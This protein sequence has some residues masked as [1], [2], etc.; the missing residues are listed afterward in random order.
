MISVMVLTLNEE[1]DLPGCLES[2]AWSDDVWVF[3]SLSTDRT[4]AIAEASGAHVIQRKFDNW[5]AH[6]NWAMENIPFKHPWVFYID[7]DE[8][9][10]E[11]LRTAIHQAVSAAE[12]HVAF[13]VERRDFLNGTWLKHVQLSAWYTRLFQPSKMRY[14]RLVN[15]VSVVD[16]T[17]GRIAGYLD[18]FPFSKGVT[19]WIQRHNDYSTKEAQQLLLNQADAPP[20]RLRDAFFAS[21]FQTRR[22]QQKQLFYRLPGRPILKFILIYFAKRGFLDGS[23]GLTYALLQSIYE[24]FIV[25]KTRELK[26]NQP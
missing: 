21:D 12:G 6:Q 22:K 14:E 20:F 10:T 8:R 9:M 24:Y 15:P 11:G 26:Q 23:A 25:L 13:E 1:G 5:A 16:G 7:A 2:I 17:T 19:Y 18:H 3:D 4:T